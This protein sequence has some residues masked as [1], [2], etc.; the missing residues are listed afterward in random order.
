MPMGHDVKSGYPA[1]I[2]LMSM[3]LL[4]RSWGVEVGSMDHGWEAT[5][6]GVVLIRL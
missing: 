2:A 6:D 5:L 3:M 4:R 1:P